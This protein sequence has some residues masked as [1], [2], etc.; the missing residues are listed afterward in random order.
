M[1]INLKGSTPIIESYKINDIINIEGI[2]KKAIFISNDNSYGIYLFEDTNEC[3]F[4]VLSNTTVLVTGQ[5]YFLRGKVVQYNDQSELKLYDFIP[6]KP[7]TERGIISFLRVIPGLNSKAE[8]IYNKFGDQAIN[9]VLSRPDD[10]KTVYGIGKATVEKVKNANIG[11]NVDYKTIIRLFELGFSTNQVIKTVNYFETATLFKL[12]KNPYQLMKLSSFSFEFCDSLAMKLGLT[13]DNKFRLNAAGISILERA[14][15]DGNVYLPETEFLSLTKKLLCL[16]LQYGELHKYINEKEI[17]YWG[18]RYELDLDRL[19]DC[20]NKKTDYILEEISEADIL[21]N[22]QFSII[23]IDDK[24]YLKHLYEAEVSF[25]EC[26]INLVNNKKI[27]YTRHEIELMLDNICKKEQIELEIQQREAIITACKYDSGIVVLNGSAGTGKTFVT[28]LI[29]KLRTAL[30]EFYHPHQT[31]SFV[32]LAPTGKATKVMKQNMND[33]DIPCYT[34]HRLLGYNGTNFTKNEHDK[35]EQNFFIIDEASMLDISIASAFIKAVSE[36]STIIFL[37][38]TKQLTSVGPGSVLKD[39]INSHTIPIITLDV[40]KRQTSLSGILKNANHVIEK[41]M[42]ETTKNTGDFY[43]MEAKTNEQIQDI[44]T[45]SM[46]RL[47]VKGFGIEDIQLLIP[48]RTTEIGINYFNY[49]LQ[50]KINPNNNG[51]KVLKTSFDIKGKTYS[52]F[53]CKKDKVMQVKNDYTRELFR[54]SNGSIVQ[55]SK[56]IGITNGE[57]GIVSD[58]YINKQGEMI[59]EVNFDG[60]YTE[61]NDVS[62]LEL[63][64]AITI[65][66]AQGSQWPATLI[67]IG[68][69]HRY[70]LSNN[71]LYTAI[72]RSIDFCGIVY[73]EKALE[74]AIE[75]E[76]DNNRYTSLDEQLINISECY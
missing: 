3:T 25:A 44:I 57:I 19:K 52:L 15:F 1:E 48:Q 39:I 11:L 17:N 8:L 5:S 40:I 42:L 4:P 37:G 53:I 30:T 2:C 9:V 50:K 76:K 54:K 59:I 27:L 66:K 22:L 33:L 46:K 72:T 43:L 68:N 31:L 6:Y 73:N 75:T 51:A 16:K 45:Q 23:K 67:V 71:I 13:S 26:L 14:A 29:V 12:T 7:T 60:Y 41:E 63:A 58:V 62:D 10:L 20:I 69:N 24:I 36:K 74:Y 28:K 70:M 65:H 55:S 32:G 49:L 61:Y 21:K 18:I 56:K 38:D 47:F 35:F 64:Y 34:I